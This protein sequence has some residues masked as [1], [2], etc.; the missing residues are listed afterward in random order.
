MVMVAGGC[1]E[2]PNVGFMDAYVYNRPAQE[3]V[4]LRGAN[5]SVDVLDILPVPKGCSLMMAVSLRSSNGRNV[6]CPIEVTLMAYELRCN[7]TI[8]VFPDSIRV[9]IAGHAMELTSHSVRNSRWP[10][11]EIWA[12]ACYVD[13]ASLCDTVGLK[14]QLRENDMMIDLSSAIRINDERLQIAQIAGHLQ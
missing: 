9:T 8:K 3:I 12:T 10:S 2:K 7:E 11:T 6:D 14:R 4:W 13:S 1:L 5:G